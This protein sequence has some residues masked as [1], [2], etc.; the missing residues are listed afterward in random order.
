MSK[1]TYC[2]IGNVVE[3]INTYTI[4][5]PLI[6]LPPPSGKIKDFILSTNIFILFQFIL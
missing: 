4:S 6:H 3:R 1:Y 5:Q 2:K